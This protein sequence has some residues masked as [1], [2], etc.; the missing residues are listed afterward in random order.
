MTS[1]RKIDTRLKIQMGGLVFKA[2]LRDADK[3]LILGALMELAQNI[4]QGDNKRLTLLT[5]LGSDE[6]SSRST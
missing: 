4:E 3:A 1:A 2:G 5:R 6:L